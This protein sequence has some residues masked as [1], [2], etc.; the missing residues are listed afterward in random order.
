MTKFARTHFQ[1][2]WMWWLSPVW[3]SLK[4]GNDS[5][6]GKVFTTSTCVMPGS[7]IHFDDSIFSSKISIFF[8]SVGVH[9][10]TIALCFNEQVVQ[11]IPVNA[12]DVSL[13][14]VLFEKQHSWYYSSFVTWTLEQHFLPYFNSLNTSKGSMLKCRPQFNKFSL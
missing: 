14:K 5:A 9:P 7:S 12:F 6:G 13:D 1:M 10:T 8:R 4:V 3:L 11:D 2:G